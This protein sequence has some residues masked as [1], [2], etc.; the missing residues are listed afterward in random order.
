VF[1]SD[2]TVASPFNSRV[3]EALRRLDLLVVADSMPGGT[4]ELADV[5]L[6]VAQWAEED[7][8][9]TNLEGRVIRRRR[10]VDPPEGMRSDL[11]II[12]D[13]ARRLTGGDGF[14]FKSSED[15]FE[16]LRSA[17]AGGRADYSGI[18]YQRLDTEPGV[19]W[20]CPGDGHPGTPR[21]FTDRFDHP[22]G[23]ARLVPV[24]WRPAAEPPDERYP[25]YFTTGRY[26]EHY[27][28]GTQTRRLERLACA[29]PAPRL[30]VHPE[31]AAP[32][33][34]TAGSTVVVKSRRGEALY[35]ADITAGIRPDTV[36]APFHWDGDGSANLL[37]I[38][39]LDPISRMPEF[40]VCAVQI[41]SAHVS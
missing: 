40:K 17:S 28:S 4:A 7:G 27:N 22:D 11:D 3:A 30:Q 38:D 19:F 2:L 34:I 36:F 32:L 10:A 5:V 1:G 29:Q 24:S 26:R 12:V 13:L 8:T 20:P 23:R 21:M 16:E 14:R 33:G 31:V 41:R 37:T 18:S 25:L 9:V 35:E 39:E 6:P 15:V